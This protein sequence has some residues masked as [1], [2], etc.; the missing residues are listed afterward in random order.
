MTLGRASIRLIIPVLV[1]CLAGLTGARA[2]TLL[3]MNLSDLCDRAGAIFS[4]T[5]LDVLPGT[6]SIGGGEL[7]VL[8]YRI[9][10][11]ESFKGSLVE[12]K[13]GR[14]AE[15]TMVG[16]IRPAEAG[17]A[18]S[19]P[20]LP[21]LPELKPGRRYLLFTTPPSAAGL[22]IMVGLGQGTFRVTGEGQG[23]TAVNRVD[24]LGLFR[25]T[26]I[27]SAPARGPVSYPWLSEQIRLEVG[28]VQLKRAVPK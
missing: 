21:D 19:V 12:T 26:G 11:E 13:G 15:V 17:G 23:S 16:K 5:V 3:R 25:E 4:G 8:T 2:T 24:N 9:R 18:V 27:E 20:F 7:P 28:R 1:A 22:S 10:V 6:V 14:I